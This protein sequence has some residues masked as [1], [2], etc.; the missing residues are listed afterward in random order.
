MSANR[1]L[2]GTMSI[3]QE[4]LIAKLEK[5][6]A[7]LEEEFDGREV[8]PALDPGGLPMPGSSSRTINFHLH[9]RVTRVTFEKEATFKEAAP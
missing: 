3:D 7:E 8:A 6:L 4:R 2:S 1:K 5:P 9:V